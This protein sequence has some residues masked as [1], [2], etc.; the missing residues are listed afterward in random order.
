VLEFRARFTAHNFEHIGFSDGAF[1]N[2]YVMFS[3]HNNATLRTRVSNGSESGTAI[4][5]S[6]LGA[7]HTYK[8]DW[9]TSQVDFYIDDV[10]VDTVTTNIPT[11]AS[12]V[13]VS[14]NAQNAAATMSVDWIHLY[15]YPDT[16]GSYT[17]CILDSGA[18]NTDWGTLTYSSTEPASTAVAVSTR[19]SNDGVSWSSFSSAIAS[20]ADI[21]SAVGRYLQYKIDLTGTATTGPQVDSLSL[22]FA[23]PTP[24][25][26]PTSTPTSSSDSG[27]TSTNSSGTSTACTAAKPSV[28]KLYA[29]LP[30]DSDTAKLYFTDEGGS[31]S[32]L[33]V[34]YGTDENNFA[35]GTQQSVEA[36]ARTSVINDLQSGQQYFFQV[37]YQNDCNPG[38]WSNILSI[39]MPNAYSTGDL[40]VSDISKDE[41]ENTPDR[42]N[43]NTTEEKYSETSSTPQKY[44]VKVKLTDSNGGAVA[45]ATVIL[46]SD[47]KQTVSD[48]DGVATFTGVEPGEH[49]LIVQADE[50]SG[51]QKITIGGSDPN[52]V[53][54]VTLRPDPVRSW[55]LFGGGALGGS[56]LLILLYFAYKKFFE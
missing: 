27:S 34:R 51:E 45:G 7:Y 26:T 22:T 19:T 4:G 55:L 5:T 32:D 40:V 53:V 48:K 56:I 16:T 49:T 28:P 50:L 14:S 35:F 23:T 47:P 37:R 2:R 39:T 9:Q 43:S 44:S 31:Y 52:L 21:P 13:I 12:N 30:E 18:T 8:I 33:I 10:L 20:A 11:L 3:T 29:I 36:G 24:T 42:T 1:F 41:A 46:H 15:E 54:S 17:S 25:P 6:Q 38:D